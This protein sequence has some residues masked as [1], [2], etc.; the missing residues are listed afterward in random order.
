MIIKYNEN[1]PERVEE[2]IVDLNVFS[3]DP[4]KRE[5]KR[6]IN[7]KK[8]NRLNSYKAKAIVKNKRESKHIS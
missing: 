5:K 6:E 7:E 8:K 4:S 2:T 3:V 1:K